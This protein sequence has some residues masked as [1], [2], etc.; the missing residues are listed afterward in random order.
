MSTLARITLYW[1]AASIL[2]G[3]LWSRLPRD[4]QDPSHP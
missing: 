3:W 4:P 2:F 1:I